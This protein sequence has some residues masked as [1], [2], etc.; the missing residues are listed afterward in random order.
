M[1]ETL[2]GLA[3]LPFAIATAI[4]LV[5]LVFVVFTHAYKFMAVVLLGFVTAVALIAQSEWWVIFLLCA[6]TLVALVWALDTDE[7][8]QTRESA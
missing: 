6:V 4:S 7:E 3:L 1:L 8:K 2:I 5:A